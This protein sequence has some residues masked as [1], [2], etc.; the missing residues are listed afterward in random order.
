MSSSV[1]S[2][3]PISSKLSKTREQH[4]SQRLG[5]EVPTDRTVERSHAADHVYALDRWL[6]R[7]LRAAIGDPP[8]RF[9]LW[10]GTR[11]SRRQSIPRRPH[12]HPRPADAP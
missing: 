1:S 11:G 5:I 12:H 8:I 2:G 3:P 7:L 9:V 4:R 10:D 6:V